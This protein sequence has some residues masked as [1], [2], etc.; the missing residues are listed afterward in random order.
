MLRGGV[1]LALLSIVLTGALENPLWV[2]LALVVMF[3]VAAITSTRQAGWS[4]PRLGTISIAILV[5]VSASLTI[6]FATG[7]VSSPLG[8]CS[9]WAAF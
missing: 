7:S 8:I 6:V 4:L 5:G 9:R 2:A 3:V 1:Q